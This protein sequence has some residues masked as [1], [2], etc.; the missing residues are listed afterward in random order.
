MALPPAAKVRRMASVISLWE[1][2]LHDK[3]NIVVSG[4][5]PYQEAW[6]EQ[7]RLYK[8]RLAE[9]IPDTLLLLQHPPTVTLG[10]GADRN[11][12]LQGADALAKMGVAMV[13]SDRGGD[14]TYHGPGQLVGYP[15]LNLSRPP[16]RQ[17]LH[18]YLRSL[19]ETLIRS[20]ARFGVAANRFQG[21]TGVWIEHPVR[22]PEKVAA[23]GV[24]VSHW[25]T[26]HGF[27]LNIAPEMAHFDL[28][29][30]CGIRSH[31]VTSL[32]AAIG[33]KIA[34]EELLQPVIAS[35]CE[36]FQLQAQTS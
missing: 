28:I 35:F 11:N 2:T 7:K 16:H 20:V 31:G 15:I 13:E 23:I 33:R 34:V 18:M 4:V 3:L 36:V 9:E 21:H 8:A 27:A 17:D 6:D 24:R 26:G 10:R 12:V 5:V 1:T 14:V 25:I 29:V 30:P 19:E 22:G 32:S